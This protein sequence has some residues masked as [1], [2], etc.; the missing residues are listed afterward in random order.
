MT[1]KSG[2]GL[3]ASHF[4]RAW[5]RLI[6]Q[7]AWYYQLSGILCR[8]SLEV[9]ALATVASLMSM[10]CSGGGIVAETSGLE[11]ALYII[12]VTIEVDGDHL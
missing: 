2:D 6:A 7:K 8:W 5:A 10:S 12:V 1:I 11:G 4:H 3:G 9:L